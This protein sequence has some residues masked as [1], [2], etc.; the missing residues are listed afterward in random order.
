MVA[1]DGVLIKE[2]WGWRNEVAIALTGR[3]LSSS[4][5]FSQV[6]PKALL[7]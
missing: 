5:R 1:G 3:C 7:M 6:S 4:N 2:I